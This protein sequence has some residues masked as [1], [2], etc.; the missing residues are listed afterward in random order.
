MKDLMKDLSLQQDKKV[1]RPQHPPIPESLLTEDGDH[2]ITICAHCQMAFNVCG[3][4]KCE[5]VPCPRLEYS[6]FD[7]KRGALPCHKNP[8]LRKGQVW[9][10]DDDKRD[11][12]PA[13]DDDD[14][15]I[16]WPP[17]RRPP[18]SNPRRPLTLLERLQRDLS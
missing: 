6:P 14:K 16:P 2:K 7:P 17:M 13:W 4:A 3:D 9:P 18:A 12:D 8:K 1:S 10:S 15:P 11:W 5:Y